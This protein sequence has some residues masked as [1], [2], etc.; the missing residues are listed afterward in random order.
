MEDSIQSDDPVMAI[1]YMASLATL[2]NKR[3]V[4][5]KDFLEGSGI[6]VQSL[7]NPEAL[8]SPYQYE[9]L[10]ENALYLSNEPALGLFLGQHHNITTHGLLGQAVLTSPNME[11]ALRV[12]L[13]YIK[14]RNQLI[15]LDVEVKGKSVTLLFDVSIVSERSRRFFLES[16]ISG[17]RSIWKLLLGEDMSATE[18]NLQFPAPEYYPLYE[19]ML[20]APVAF[21]QEINSM[22]FPKNSLHR[23]FIL[24]NPLLANIAEQQCEALL[25]S[26][27]HSKGLPV[28]IRQHLLKNPGQFPKLDALA[29]EFNIHPRTL[30]RRL[31][32]LNTS[33]QEILD[34]VRKR[35]ALQYLHTTNWTID[36]IAYQL[37]YGDPSNFRQAFKKWTG[38]PPS[39]FRSTATLQKPHGI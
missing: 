36:E 17:I 22:R 23:A 33:Y 37:G 16:M 30:R 14:T 31:R 19:Q 11:K 21:N 26:L 29:E 13:R 6:S 32:N 38:N 4:S 28:R 2:L 12:T 10:I 8:I 15:N 9:T 5:S 27:T 39:Y 20:K 18:I 3:G 34:D 1:N 35:L 7:E 24:S 25:N